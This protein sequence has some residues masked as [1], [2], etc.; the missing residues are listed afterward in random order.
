MNLF[1]ASLSTKNDY[2]AGD[3]NILTLLA[4]LGAP[5]YDRSLLAVAVLGALPIQAWI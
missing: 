4:M 1:I 2:I 3:R 5:L